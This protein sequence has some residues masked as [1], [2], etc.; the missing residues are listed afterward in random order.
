MLLTL[1][2]SRVPDRSMLLGVSAGWH[3][4]LDVLEARVRGATP[5]P[6]WDEWARLREE[7][8]GRFPA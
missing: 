3:G 4:H 8:A 2:H 5:A 7:Y 6:F 1:V